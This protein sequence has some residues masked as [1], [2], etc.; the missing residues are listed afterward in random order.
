MEPI[1]VGQLGSGVMEVRS[2]EPAAA[3]GLGDDPMFPGPVSVDLKLRKV[4][5]RVL[6]SG[7]IA[8][9][10]KLKCSRCLEEFERP[11]NAE[12]A[13]EYEEGLP[14]ESREDV[15]RDEDPDLG[16]FEPPFLDPSDDLRQF[17]VLAAPAYPVC[18]ENCRGLCPGCGTNL[19]SGACECRKSEKARPFEGLKT[20]LKKEQITDG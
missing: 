2:D 16:H 6:V 13:L 15:V 10:L 5:S 7:T 8:S 14:A 12:V 4:G 19:N 9:R 17:L 3:L 11:T 1:D 20:L 18:R